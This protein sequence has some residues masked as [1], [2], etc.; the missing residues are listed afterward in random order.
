MY[1]GKLDGLFMQLQAEDV[2]EAEPRSGVEGGREFVGIMN[3]FVDS[4]CHQLS[5]FSALVLY[6]ATT[7]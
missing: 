5:R 2:L 4:G 6:V 1:G 7:H 3:K